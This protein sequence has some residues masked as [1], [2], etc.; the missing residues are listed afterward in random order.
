MM[1]F[2]EIRLGKARPHT[3]RVKARTGARR[4]RMTSRLEVLEERTLLSF[5]GILT[6]TPA[7]LAETTLIPIPTPNGT[8][9]SSITR[10]LETVSISPTMTTYQTLPGEWNTSPPAETA[11]PNTLYNDNPGGPITLTLSNPASVFGLE[12]QWHPIPSNDQPITMEADFYDG[13]TLEGSISLPITESLNTGGALLFAAQTDQA[14]TSVVLSN[15]SADTPGIQIAQVRYGTPPLTGSAGNEITGVEGSTTGTVQLGTF[16]DGNQA[17]TPANYT[18][19]PGSVVVN[20]GDGSAPQTLDAGNLTAIGTPNGVTWEIKAAHTYTEEGTYAYTVTVID[21]GVGIGIPGE[22][23]TVDGSAIIADAALTAGPATALTPNT[24]VALPSST[25]VAT[26]TDANTFAT[27]A[28]YTATIDWGD[29][30]PESTGTVVATATPGVFNV[31]GPHTYANPGVFT[32]LVTVHDDGGSQV[33]IT[34]K[35]TVTDLT[36]IA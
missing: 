10:G 27:T 4:R 24:G 18:T 23:T 33:V 30:S 14:F 6:P 35:A 9:V 25:V 12:M 19:P 36:V 20:W 5:A 15:P 28:D 31:E 7:Y 8:N 3:D 22:A 2:P 11:N 13:A 21:N 34:G 17:A 29:G 1:T 32:T 26:F 16:Y